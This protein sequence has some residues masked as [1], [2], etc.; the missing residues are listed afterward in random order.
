[1]KTKLQIAHHTDIPYPVVDLKLKELI[2]P[3]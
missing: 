2:C 3:D 1:M